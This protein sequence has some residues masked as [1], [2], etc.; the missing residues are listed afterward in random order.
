[1]TPTPESD[2]AAKQGDYLKGPAG[3]PGTYGKQLVDLD[4]TSRL[5]RERDKANADRLRL[6]EAFYKTWT[7]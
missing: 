5:E 3:Y 1:M 4:V 7:V 2:L 6:R